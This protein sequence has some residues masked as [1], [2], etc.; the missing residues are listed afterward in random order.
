MHFNKGSLFYAQLDRSFPT[1]FKLRNG[2][3]FKGPSLYSGKN[4]KSLQLVYG[5]TAGIQGAQYCS[6]GSLTPELVKGKI[7]VCQRGGSSRAKKAE[8]VL[9]AGGAAMLLVNTDNE[10]EDIFADPHIIPATPLGALAAS[11][12]DALCRSRGLL[13]FF[14]LVSTLFGTFFTT[15]NLY[16]YYL[17]CCL[18]PFY[19]Y[20]QVHL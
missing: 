20:I 9:F 12:L 3:L 2:Q 10:G 4:I 13:S 15:L 14:D 1:T 5:A 17:I 11:A 16:D 8:Q 18:M 7:V 6:N 19:Q